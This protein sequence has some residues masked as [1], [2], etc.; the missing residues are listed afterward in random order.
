MNFT[1]KNN[2]NYKEMIIECDNVKFSS[3]LVN[4]EERIELARELINAAYDLIFNDKE[5][6]GGKLAD[7]LNENF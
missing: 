7:I 4:K 3:G 1:V 2:W 5:E 6:V